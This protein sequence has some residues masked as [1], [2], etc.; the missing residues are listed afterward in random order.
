MQAL[1]GPSVTLTAAD[2]PPT[3]E[4]ALTCALDE[5]Q[6]DPNVTVEWRWHKDG[7]LM[8]GVSS[9]SLSIFELEKDATF[10]C[11]A[12][13]VWSGGITL[14]SLWGA[15]SGSLLI[16][17]STPVL[18]APTVTPDED[19]TLDTVLTCNSGTP[20]DPDAA[21]AAHLTIEKDWLRNGV[22][23]ALASDTLD[24]GSLNPLS[25]GD[26]L[27]CR[28]RVTDGTDTSAFHSAPAVSVTNR[29][30]S[31]ADLADTSVDE[32]TEAALTLP[33]IDADGDTLSY[34]CVSGCPA[35]VSFSG[36][37]PQVRWTPGYADAGVYP[38]TL[39]VSDGTATQDVGWQLTVNAVTDASL[40]LIGSSDFG[41]V[42]HDGTAP[43]TLTLQNS[44]VAPATNVT[45]SSLSAP[46]SFGAGS[47][48]NTSSAFVLAGGTSCTVELEFS[49]AH[50]ASFTQTLGVSYHNSETTVSFDR[51]V[52]A[53]VRLVVEPVYPANGSRWTDWVRFQDEG[54]SIV[55]QPGNSCRG[56]TEDEENACIHG[57]EMRKVVVPGETSCTDLTISDTLGQFSWGCSVISG[58]ATFYSVFN[59]NSSFRSLVDLTATPPQFKTATVTV[60]KSGLP[61]DTSVSAAWWE[62]AA[63]DFIELPDNSLPTDPVEVLSPTA[64]KVTVYYFRDANRL[65]SGYRLSADSSHVVVI[66]PQQYQLMHNGSTENGCSNSA[67]VMEQC[68]IGQVNGN[69]NWYEINLHGQG[70][71]Q[72]LYLV[73]KDA[74]KAST[75]NSVRRS[76]FSSTTY[77]LQLEASVTSQGI[78]LNNIT[79]NWATSSSGYGLSM[80]NARLNRIHGFRSNLSVQFG[81]VLNNARDNVFN[82]IIVT[83]VVSS[84]GDGTGIG[85]AGTS[86]RNRFVR[87]LL[88]AS[89]NAGIKLFDGADANVFQNVTITHSGSDLGLTGAITVYS[90]RNQFANITITGMG[91]PTNTSPMGAGIFL[92]GGSDCSAGIT[93]SADNNIFHNTS[94]SHATIGVYDC[95]TD[96]NTFSGGLILQNNFVGCA[97]GPTS[98]ISA[99]TCSTTTP[100]SNAANRAATPAFVGKTAD[101]NHPGASGRL[102]ASSASITS[103]HSFERPSRIWGKN[104]TGPADVTNRGSCYGTACQ[105]YDL[106]LA[107]AD[108]AVRNMTHAAPSWTGNGAFTPGITCP[109]AVHGDVSGLAETMYSQNLVTQAYLLHATEVVGDYSGNEDGI[110]NSNEVCLYSPNYGYYQGHGST[111]EA[112]TFVDGTTSGVSGARVYAYPSNGY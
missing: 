82:D 32:G 50:I 57:G 18:A 55:E 91:H 49:P 2:S 16:R 10:N 45:L 110:C 56:V 99:V 34:A 1:P 74:G 100:F 31:I 21:D 61:L 9:A 77:A 37:A 63:H 6:T 94:V 58:K 71:V 48:C 79:A 38:M 109:D 88:G 47:T 19:V 17:N 81:I 101:T 23:L 29:A 111:A 8:T 72:G 25:I 106:A 90:D 20:T 92:I 28:T 30:P 60:Q 14:T 78:K 73:S 24:L 66:G 95:A 112:C 103:W 64:G 86:Q 105:I 41:I 53:Q 39:R 67:A 70:A 52:D 15:S 85:I 69:Y 102:Y 13:L 98:G 27:T 59:Q 36:S 11:S 35:G 5:L 96:N 46:F 40:A 54:F 43:L 107:S 108:T 80:Q 89:G 12:R 83:N 42:H 4:S 97:N 62:D 22:S 65:T 104:G 75:F 44:G 3:V 51:T 87:L 93:S 7:L 33:L 76:M 26:S 84:G 68:V